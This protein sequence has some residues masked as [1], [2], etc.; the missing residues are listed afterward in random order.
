MA[1]RGLLPGRSGRR[2]R[3]A[4][5]PAPL[6]ALQLLTLSPPGTNTFDR[7]ELRIQKRLIDLHSPADVVKQITSITIE[8]GV[9]VEVT[10]AE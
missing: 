6:S 8:T 7:F 2:R 9:E 4:V 5:R 3:F 10:I 1:K